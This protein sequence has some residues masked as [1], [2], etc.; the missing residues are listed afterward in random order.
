MKEGPRI[1]SALPH[2]RQMEEGDTMKQARRTVATT[3]VSTLVFALVTV[4]GQA[5]AA[6]TTEVIRPS[7]PGDWTFSQDG[8]ATG[9]FQTGPSTP[10][11]GVGSYGYNV[12]NGDDGARA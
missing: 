12:P 9:G 11:A 8:V 1:T 10:P 4:S 2:L 6:T 5:G 3:I 7:S